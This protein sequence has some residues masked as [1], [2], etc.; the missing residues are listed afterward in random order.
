M[1]FIFI[2]LIASIFYANAHSH[3]SVVYNREK[4]ALDVYVYSPVKDSIDVRLYDA[5][6]NMVDEMPRGY[7]DAH[8]EVSFD[9][10]YRRSGSYTVIV[11]IGNKLSL[12]KNVNVKK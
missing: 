4:I 7:I 3:L 6:D 12:K 10:S 8:Y 1:K 5:R 9:F 2:I 11:D